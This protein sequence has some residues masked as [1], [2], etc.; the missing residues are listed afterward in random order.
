M[1]EYDHVGMLSETSERK[2]GLYAHKHAISK[3]SYSK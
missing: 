3:Q 2:T 1:T